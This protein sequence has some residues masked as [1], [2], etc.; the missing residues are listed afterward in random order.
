MSKEIRKEIRIVPGWTA[1]D[2]VIH[3]KPVPPEAIEAARRTVERLKNQA[4][5][6]PVEKPDS[7]N[8]S[9]FERPELTDKFGFKIPKESGFK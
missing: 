7:P 9:E 6:R 1:Y 2:Y 5:T 8:I 4:N 3:G